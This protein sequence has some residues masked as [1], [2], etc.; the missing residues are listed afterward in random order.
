MRFGA[1]RRASG[2]HTT[3]FIPPPCNTDVQRVFVEEGEVCAFY[4]FVTTTPV[5]RSRPSSV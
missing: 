2:R 1:A 3:E 4:D 5:G